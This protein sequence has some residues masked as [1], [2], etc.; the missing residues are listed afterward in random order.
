LIPFGCYCKISEEGTP[1]NSM[2]ARTRGAVAL[3]PSG[4]VQGGHN[5]FALNT[6]RASWYG[7]SGCGYR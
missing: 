5:F 1:R 7:A 6:K 3:G 2:L 4:N